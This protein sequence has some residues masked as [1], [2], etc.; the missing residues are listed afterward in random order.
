MFHKSLSLT[1]CRKQM[2]RSLKEPTLLCLLLHNIK[3]VYR[4][5]ARPLSM[6]FKSR[7]KQSCTRKLFAFVRE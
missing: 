2:S 6:S 7:Y 5:A 3:A 1:V 4:L